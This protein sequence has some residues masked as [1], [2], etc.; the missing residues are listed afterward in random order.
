MSAGTGVTHSEYNPSKS[1][2]VHFLQ[3]WLLP[4]RAGLEPSYEQR[5]FPAEERRG[6]LRLVASRDA[7]EGSVRVHQDVDLYAALLRDGEVVEHALRPGRHAWVQLAR[8]RCELGGVSLEVGDG[9]A[10]SQE[11]KLRL[12]GSDEAE[13][14]VFDLA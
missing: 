2:L 4:E 13:A 8:G 7:R 5:H 6:A 1:E 11:S 3:I 12:A 14:L 9:A 10:L